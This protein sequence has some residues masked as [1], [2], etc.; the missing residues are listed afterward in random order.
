[1]TTRRSSTPMNSS[2]EDGGGRGS[3]ARCRHRRPPAPIA[4]SCSVR[5]RPSRTC[6]DG[7]RR[8]GEREPD[9]TDRRDEPDLRWAEAAG[10]EDDRDER[11]EDAQRDA[12]SEDDK[13]EGDH[14]ARIPAG[15]GGG[16]VGTC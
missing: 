13:S 12:E 8:D 2:G 14:R 6:R 1:M 3:P 15:G 4:Q 7:E 16:G 11:I 5:A 10:G 9:R